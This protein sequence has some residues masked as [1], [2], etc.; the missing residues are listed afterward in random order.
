MRIYDRN[1]NKKIEITRGDTGVFDINIEG[2]ELEAEDTAIFTVKR[3][4]E[5]DTPVIQK[6]IHPLTESFTLS[7]ADTTI[8]YGTY[9][10]DIQLNTSDGQIITLFAP[11]V[12]EVMRGV[13]E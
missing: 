7:G 1:Y 12:F 10:Y 13:T 6:T 2:Y 9:V 4:V 3:K 8:D 5:D 11:G